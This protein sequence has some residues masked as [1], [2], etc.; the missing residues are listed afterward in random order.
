[1][2]LKR[3]TD[4]VRGNVLCVVLRLT[5]FCGTQATFQNKSCL[6]PIQNQI[7]RQLA[8]AS[9]WPEITGSLIRPPVKQISSS[10]TFL[11]EHD[12]ETCN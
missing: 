9:V 5:L 1:M 4:I 3:I 2:A 12:T 7:D 6:I 8:F 10:S 11:V